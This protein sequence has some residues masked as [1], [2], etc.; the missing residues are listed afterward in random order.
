MVPQGLALEQD[1]LL[2]ALSTTIE[3]RENYI[4]LKEARIKALK[5]E[6]KERNLDDLSLTF[7]LYRKLYD[8]YRSYQFDSAFTYVLKMQETAYNLDDNEKIMASK[9]SLGVI[10]RSAGMFKEAFDSLETVKAEVFSDSLKIAYYGE[11]ALTYYVLSAYNNEK[12]YTE[13]NGKIGDKY[14]DSAISLADT[15]S[16]TYFKLKGLEAEARGQHSDAERY[17]NT[18]LNHFD[19]DRHQV[20]M[21]SYSLGKISLALGNE[22]ESLSYFIQA[23]IADVQSVTKET[24]ALMDLAKTL[25]HHGKVG[26]AYDFINQSADD[27]FF[28]GA[29]HRILQVSAILPEIEAAKL[30]SVEYQRKRLLTFSI[31]VTLLSLLVIGF[32]IIIFRQYRLLNLAK[33]KL[34]LANARLQ[35]VNE[36]LT[37]ANAIKEE[38]IGHSFSKDSEYL[39][40]LDRFKKDLDRKL[41]SKKYEDLKFV[42]KSV[43]LKKEREALYIKFDEVFLKL[44]PNF[45][46]EFN[47]YFNE[48]YQLRIKRD[49]S[50]PIEL[51]IFALIRLGIMDHEQI[52]SILGYSVRTI[53]NYKTKVKSRSFVSNDEFEK[54]IMEIKAF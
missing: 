32:A 52:A 48:E 8:E 50:L 47:S 20:A 23:A 4:Q 33:D 35:L 5:N 6:L 19:I 49:G 15:S 34:T 43:D 3:E 27:A 16:L 17:F 37:E 30:A 12:Y 39:N 44:F 36:N 29:R 41:I 9:L 14:L 10:L 25:Y 40:K 24:V 46:K 54:K 22:D 18:I 21:A 31:V 1:S 7:P 26:L 45:L 42:M 53:Y 13:V 51:R 11:M 28:Y 38:Y 2:Q